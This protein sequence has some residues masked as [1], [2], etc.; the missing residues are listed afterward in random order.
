MPGIAGERN[1]EPSLQ[2]SAFTRRG[3][4][5]ETCQHISVGRASPHVR[6]TG[7]KGGVA[8]SVWGGQ[9]VV[10]NRSNTGAV[11]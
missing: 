7:M 5:M 9:G 2:G 1:A 11:S 3:E 10:D 8:R 6:A 4:Q